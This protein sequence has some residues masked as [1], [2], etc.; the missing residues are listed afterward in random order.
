[1]FARFFF[2]GLASSVMFARI[3]E[4]LTGSRGRE[5]VDFF[6]DCPGIFYELGQVKVTQ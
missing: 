3:L 1:M 2:S 6:R 5:D 4:S